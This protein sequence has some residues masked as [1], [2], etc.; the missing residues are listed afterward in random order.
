MSQP[1]YLYLRDERSGFSWVGNKEAA[2]IRHVFPPGRELVGARSMY[3][4]LCEIANDA[5]SQEFKIGKKV[6]A[7]RAG[8][9]DPDVV[10]RYM[11]AFERIGIVQISHN[12]RDD[13]SR[14]ANTYR[15]TTPESVSSEIIAQMTPGARGFVQQATPSESEG[16]V[17]QARG[18]EQAPSNQEERPSSNEEGAGTSPSQDSSSKNGEA[19]FSLQSPPSVEDGERLFDAKS[20]EDEQIEEVWN[21]F[22]EVNSPV[23][24][25]L[26]PQRKRMLRT[27]LKEATVEEAKLAID[28]NRASPWHRERGKHNLSDVFK[29]NQQRGE[30]LRDKIDRFIRDAQ[31]AGKDR[32]QVL[33][34]DRGMVQRHK[35]LVLRAHQPGASEKVTEDAK[36]STAWLEEHGVEVRVADGWPRF[37]DKEA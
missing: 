16:S 37:V 17:E 1:D 2:R 26:S 29:P 19:N 27:V 30:K 34:V 3:L 21:Y 23:N 18:V 28:G 15:M 25:T 13:N 9:K 6:I 10:G 11:E 5:R 35:D 20:V 14:D 32:G 8:F 22:C 31:Q 24:K 7:E 4:A 12:Y 36:G 33:S